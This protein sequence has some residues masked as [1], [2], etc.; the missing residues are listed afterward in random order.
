[1]EIKICENIF[2]FE[3]VGFGISKKYI[4]NIIF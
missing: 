4:L 2:K 1:M 3:M